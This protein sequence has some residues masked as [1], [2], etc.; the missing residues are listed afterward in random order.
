M[1]ELHL[2]TQRLSEVT[3]AHH[4]FQQA[5][6]RGKLNKIWA[7]LSGASAKMLDLTTVT[8]HEPIIGRHYSGLL[9]VPIQQI[10]GSEGRS[11]DFD[12]H[13]NPLHSYLETRW[14]NLARAFIAGVTLPPV[15]L[16][17]VGDTYFVQDGHHRVSVARAL[18][19]TYIDAEV[20][21]WELAKKSATSQN[22]CPAC[23]PTRRPACYCPTTS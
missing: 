19:Q 6:S 21:I 11:G 15:Q 16:I 20:T 23:V 3:Q 13:F 12:R 2:A 8:A 10:R 1:F 4:L 22:S 17:Q 14:L 18:G 7:M 9:I 5:Y